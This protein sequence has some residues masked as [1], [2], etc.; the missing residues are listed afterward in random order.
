LVLGYEAMADGVKPDQIVE[1]VLGAHP[2]PTA[3]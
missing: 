1:D 3:D 2:A